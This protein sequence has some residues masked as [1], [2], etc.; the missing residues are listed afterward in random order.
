[1]SSCVWSRHIYCSSLLETLHDFFLKNSHTTQTA[2]LAA[3]PIVI[4]AQLVASSFLTAII[5]MAKE[6]W[7]LL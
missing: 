1:M 5:C 6:M 4:A 7:T 3:L 2:S